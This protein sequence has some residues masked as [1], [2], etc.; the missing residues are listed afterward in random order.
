MR[1]PYVLFPSV[2]A[3]LCLMTASS[4]AKPV[5]A[6][7]VEGFD[8]GVNNWRDAASAE[9]TFVPAGGP[10]GSSYAS[11][12]FN[13]VN[14]AG[15][16]PGSREASTILLRG[17]KLAVP[18][19]G[20]FVA[21][22]GA[23]FGDWLSSVGE[24]RL[25]VRHNT[26][27][28]LLFFARIA[29]PGNSPAYGVNFPMTVAPNEWTELVVPIDRNNPSLFPQGAGTPEMLFDTVFS[30]VG[31]IQF[32]F[33]TPTSL[34]GIDQDYTL[35]IDNI[36]LTRVPEPSTIALAGIAGVTFLALRRANRRKQA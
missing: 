20:E 22:D 7:V 13:L 12:N 25:M 31:N 4:M 8:M 27:E 5:V 3:F 15:G 21:S 10:D 6:P 14:V 29:V 2:V 16:V 24:L 9:L 30:E 11:T 28:D 26:P 34:G 32:G 17:Q 18:G 23:F 19:I 33:Y 1:R 36:T 35:D